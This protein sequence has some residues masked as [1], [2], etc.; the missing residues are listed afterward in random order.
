MK[1]KKPEGLT[2]IDL[3]CGAGGFSRR[4]KQAGYSP[5]LGFDKCQQ[6]KETYEK[7][8][9]APCIVGDICEYP[10]EN[11]LDKIGFRPEEVDIIIGGPP[12]QGFSPAGEM[13]KDDKRNQLYG[14]FVDVV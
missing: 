9:C 8:I 6:A 4:F 7:N 1:E 2:L 13:R 5:V 12:C 14:Q 10:A 11:M 3:F